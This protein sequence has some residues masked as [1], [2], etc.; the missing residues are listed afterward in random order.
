M[1]T[2]LA[3]K[4]SFGGNICYLNVC[5]QIVYCR[6]AQHGA[7]DTIGIKFSDIQEWEQI[8]L[9][10]LLDELCR[11]APTREKSLLTIILSRDSLAEEAA[12]LYRPFD[13]DKIHTN[14]ADIP[15]ILPPLSY[16]ALISTRQPQTEP[17]LP[18][19]QITHPADREAP[20]ALNLDIPTFALLINGNDIDTGHYK[21]VVPVSKLLTDQEAVSQ[22]MKQVKRGQVPSNYKDYI[23][24]R[25]CFGKKDTNRA[26]LE[27]AYAASQEFRYFPLSKRLRIATDI[28]DLLLINKDQLIELMVA[29]GHPRQLAEW[30]FLGME[31]AYRK[32]SLDFYVQ[33]LTSK[34][35]VVDEEN[36]YW[37]RKPD[38]VVCV[39]PPRNA[40]CSASLIA[41]F[42]LLSGNTLVVKPPLQSPV[43]TLFLWRNVVHESLKHNQAPD[44]TVNLV[45]GNSELI[46]DEWLNSQL[47]NDLIFIGDS[48]TGLKIGARAYENGKKPILELSG[49]DMMFVWKDAPL[50]MAVQSLLDG[51]MGST[52][53][54][55]VPKKAFIHEDVFESFQDLFLSAVKNLRI[56]LPTDPH[57][58]L[59]PVMKI[60]EFFE[61]LEEALAKGAELL[62]GGYRVNYKAIPDN[63]G[64]FITPT[65]IKVKDL[66]K[67]SQMRCVN[68]ENFFPLI[69]LIRVSADARAADKGTKDMA[70]FKKMVHVANHNEY[71]LRVSAWASSPFYVNKF[72]EQIHNSGLLRINC[73]H[74][75]FSPFLAT[76]GGTRKTGGPYG[77]LNYVWQKT[78]HLQGVTVTRIRK[79]SQ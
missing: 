20:L 63:H 5:G 2:P 4:F 18:F 61:F 51:F 45:V 77:E 75:G 62:C 69:P 52:Q 41:G 3:L 17:L 79:K 29:E 23:Y 25:Y 21:Y 56:G 54:C 28:H 31:Q 71:G 14:I 60:P 65:V 12:R 40:P 44:G 26:A 19:V 57:V 38:G 13:K 72:S 37:K 22:V 64:Q 43:S 76:H 7:L 66:S 27:A 70:I 11:T 59:S 49:N 10:S 73:R 53:V 30:E 74:A 1:G 58:T 50:E 42:A 8:I 67:A 24:A 33:H 47:V 55:M 9:L 32:P 78:S 6:Y 46:V 68:E 34:I 36:L 48:K 35:A 16:E 39:S 15:Q